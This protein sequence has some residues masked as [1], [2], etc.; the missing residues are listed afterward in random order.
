MLNLGIVYPRTAYRLFRSATITVLQTYMN[1]LDMRINQAGLSFPNFLFTLAIGVLAAITVAR[2]VP[3][4]IEHAA[5]DKIIQRLEASE[6]SDKA[7][8]RQMFTTSAG[9]ENIKSIDASALKILR[10]DGHN[11]VTYS[12]EY[13]IHLYGNAS[14]VFAFSKDE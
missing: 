8:L 4:W 9:I 11:V 5:V 14:L 12:Y 2:C 7:A 1:V 6:T 3:A 10:K 13:G